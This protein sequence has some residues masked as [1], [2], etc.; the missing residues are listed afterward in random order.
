MTNMRYAPPAYL[1]QRKTD[2]ACHQQVRKKTAQ[3]NVSPWWH[4]WCHLKRSAIPLPE[5]VAAITFLVTLKKVKKMNI[6]VNWVMQSTMISCNK[7]CQLLN[8]QRQ[9][10]RPELCW[11]PKLAFPHLCLT[12]RILEGMNAVYYDI[13]SALVLRSNLILFIV[14][15]L[16]NNDWGLL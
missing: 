14:G 10:L 12:W 1:C 2:C 9:D 16:I 7:T 15:Y 13:I 11:L 8:F 6:V 4:W 3:D 5:I